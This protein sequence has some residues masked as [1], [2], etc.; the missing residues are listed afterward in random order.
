MD[1]SSMDT[2]KWKIMKRV[3]RM[4]DN[5]VLLNDNSQTYSHAFFVF[6]MSCH[7]NAVLHLNTLF[8]TIFYEECQ[9]VMHSCVYIELS[10][11]VGIVYYLPYM[12]NAFLLLSLNT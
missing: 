6:N 3:T 5:H 2:T 8:E 12:L 11:F 7:Q 9:Y 1:P 4:I 10:T